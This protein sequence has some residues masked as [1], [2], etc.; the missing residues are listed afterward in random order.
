MSKKKKIL[1]LSDDLRAHSGV[2]T[3]SR[4]II[5]NTVS[6]YDWVQLGAMVQ[7]PDQGKIFDLSEETARI[8]GVADASVKLYCNS[9]YG[10]PDV[11]RELI[12]MEQPDA[13][14]HFTDPRFWEWLYSMEHEIRQTTPIIYYTIWDSTPVPHWNQKYYESCDLLLAISKQTYG[15]VKE[16]LK[17][18]NYEDWQIQYVPHG[19]NSDVFYPIEGQDGMLMTKRFELVGDADFVV[20][21]NS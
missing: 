4:E 19:I 6:E 1:L 13:I 17:N 21:Y 14:M 2:G 9:G 15:I 10:N 12:A 11:L 16:C 18:S 7:H 20:F 3:M 5:L 8:T